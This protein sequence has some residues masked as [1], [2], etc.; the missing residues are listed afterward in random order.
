VTVVA[1]AELE[2]PRSAADLLPWVYSAL[3]RFDTKELKRD[4][5]DGKHFAG[6]LVD[7]LL[8]LGLFASAFYNASPLVT[9]TYV[10]G[11]QN[12][13]ASVKDDRASPGSIQYVEVTVADRDYEDAKRMELM[14]RDG[15]APGYGQIIA[16]GR[17]HA[18]TELRG[19]LEALDHDKLVAQHLER[20]D[21]AVRKKAAKDYPDGTALVVRVDDA[22]PFRQ[23]A[24][25]VQLRQHAQTQLVPLLSSREFRALVFV[26]SQGLY[27]PFAL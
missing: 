24:D 13:D 8:P 21:V 6:E 3:A 15:M 17:R 10:F 7:E 9:I 11:D 5:R 23:P 18:R 25:A 20:A 19:E 27:L 16:T 2:E 1:Q 4:A 14:S 26:G 12:H 22:V